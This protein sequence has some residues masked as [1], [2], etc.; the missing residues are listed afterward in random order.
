MKAFFIIFEELSL[1][2]FFL[3]GESA[4]LTKVFVSFCYVIFSKQSI[5]MDIYQG[6]L[7][8]PEWGIGE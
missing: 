6:Y 8:K 4:S 1:K 7:K 5:Y 2:L 3:E